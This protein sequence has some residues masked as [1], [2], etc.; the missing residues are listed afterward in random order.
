MDRYIELLSA[1]GAVEIEPRRRAGRTK[2]VSLTG[3]GMSLADLAM[4]F[5]QLFQ[6]WPGKAGRMSFESSLGQ[7]V[8]DSKAE[9]WGSQILWA[10]AR[11]HRTVGALERKLLSLR[12]PEDWDLDSV[13]K[14]DH[15]IGIMRR[16]GQLEPI[17]PNSRPREYR[18]TL[19]SH[20]GAGCLAYAVAIELHHQ[21]RGFIPPSFRVIAFGLY[22][23][24][25]LIQADEE[26]SGVIQVNIPI[27]AAGRMLDVNY[28][29]ENGRMKKMSWG[30]A[31]NPTAEGIGLLYSW[32]APM[33]GLDSVRPEISG[34]HD[35]FNGVMAGVQRG[36]FAR[37]T[38]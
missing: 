16:T 25:H 20:K 11:G 26:H 24:G 28:E 17:D 31:K 9:G 12:S 27:E 32:L 38:S 13:R 22:Q 5:E 36:L 23:V 2:D 34:D 37:Q 4:L 30:R 1:S 10:C 29:I 21:P 3:Y 35:F 7:E 18:P 33:V 19:W 6:E 14:I 15:R 8:I